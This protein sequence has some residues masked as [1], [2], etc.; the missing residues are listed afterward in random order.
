MS[1]KIHVKASKEFILDLPFD[2]FDDICED[3][4]SIKE[5]DKIILE[6]IEK[7]HGFKFDSLSFVREYK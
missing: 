5:S 1:I 3:N 7:T 6:E 4:M 2:S